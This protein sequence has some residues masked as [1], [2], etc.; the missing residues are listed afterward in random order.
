MKACHSSS[1]RLDSFS[2]HLNPNKP[3]NLRASFS[4]GGNAP[5]DP[6]ANFNCAVKIYAAAGL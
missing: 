4:N 6:T 1:N 3:I 2:I 5:C